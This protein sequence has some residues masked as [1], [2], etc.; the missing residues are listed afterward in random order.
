MIHLILKISLPNP[1]SHLDTK[2]NWESLC[3][4]WKD[5]CNIHLPLSSVVPGM[6][7]SLHTQDHC[8]HPAFVK[9]GYNINHPQELCIVT[10]VSCVVWRRDFF[11]KMSWYLFYLLTR[12]QWSNPFERHMLKI[13][14]CSIKCAHK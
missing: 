1:V 11:Y 7:L 12:Y 10:T 6:C 4:F 14:K 2:Y 8:S 13:G 9:E 5:S 3:D